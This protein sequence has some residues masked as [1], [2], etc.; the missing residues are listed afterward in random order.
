MLIIGL[1]GGIGSG[2][3]IVADLFAR[4]RIP[5]I[6]ADIIARE[7]TAIGQPALNEIANH[8][9]QDILLKDKSLDRAA[10]RKRIF[11]Q[12]AERIWLEKLLHPI[13]LEKIDEYVN[14]LQAPYCIVVIPLLL[15]TGTQSL[16]HHTLLVEASEQTRIKR[17]MARDNISEE[18]VKAII[19]TQASQEER[20]QHAD[21]IIHND[22][23]LHDIEQAVNKLHQK[24]L[25]I[26][27]K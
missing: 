2:K 15:E 5:V 17:V 21:E 25:N 16:I 26:S 10:L 11:D 6:D 27:K 12:P 23:T 22:G 14:E 1:T 7:V 9:G 4:H 18:Q 8:F 24:Y 13:I 20:H 3:S 19:A